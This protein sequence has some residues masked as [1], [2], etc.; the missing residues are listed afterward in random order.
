MSRV[1][2][3]LRIWKEGNGAD[4]D[5]PRICSAEF[6]MGS[7]E[8]EQLA[9][10]AEEET[11]PREVAVDLWLNGHATAVIDGKSVSRSSRVC[12]RA[13][14]RF[15]IHTPG[16]CVNIRRLLQS[17]LE[18]S[19]GTEMCVVVEADDSHIVWHLYSRKDHGKVAL[20]QDEDERDHAPPSSILYKRR[21]QP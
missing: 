8:A 9:A 13:D 21:N 19:R 3:R 18:L 7:L 5:R 1:P 11:P 12:W 20:Q 6:K 16:N 4:N 2:F 14:E 10:Y 17:R 15:H